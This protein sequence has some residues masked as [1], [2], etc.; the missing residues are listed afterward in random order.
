LVRSERVVAA[1]G[2]DSEN[3]KKFINAYD[4]GNIQMKFGTVTAIAGV[5]QKLNF[6]I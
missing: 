4:P 1:T 5:T 6:T 2:H 3:F